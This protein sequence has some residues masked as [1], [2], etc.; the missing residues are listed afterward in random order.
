MIAFEAL[1]FKKGSGYAFK[2]FLRNWRNKG[3]RSSGLLR[4]P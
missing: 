3:T 1:R 4:K 2:P